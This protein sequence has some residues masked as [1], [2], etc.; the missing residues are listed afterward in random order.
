MSFLNQETDENICDKCRYKNDEY[1]SDS[2]VYS[3]CI[4][5]VKGS[6][7]TEKLIKEIDVMAGEAEN[8]LR[9]A[10]NDEDND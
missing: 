3:P 9:S 7:F 4:D 8:L 5:C 10:I 1:I 2:G 6:N